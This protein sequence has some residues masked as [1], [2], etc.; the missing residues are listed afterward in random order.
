MIVGADV[1]IGI[2]V[3][4]DVIPGVGKFVMKSEGPD[5]AGDDGFPGK[6]CAV[7]ALQDAKDV[8]REAG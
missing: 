5:V 2:R 6:A 7:T 4:Q 8:L 3:W 1:E